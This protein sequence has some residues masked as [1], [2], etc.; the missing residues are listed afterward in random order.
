LLEKEDMAL[1]LECQLLAA[2]EC[3]LADVQKGVKFFQHSFFRNILDKNKN[4]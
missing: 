2:E 1:E 3:L 4:F